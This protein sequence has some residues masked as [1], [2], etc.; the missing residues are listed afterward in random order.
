MSWNTDEVLDENLALDFDVDA[1]EAQ[2]P[3]SF[4]LL[5]KGEY[6][7]VITGM[8]P[9]ASKKVEG[10]RYVAMEVTIVAGKAKGRKV[11]GNFT[12]HNTPKDSTADAAERAAKAVSIGRGQIKAAFLAVGVTGS[13]VI[14]LLAAKQPIVV[15]IGVEKGN[16]AYP[17]DKNSIRG[18]KA[19]TDAQW[20]ALETGDEPAEPTAKTPAT[21]TKTTKT[22]TRPSF[23]QKK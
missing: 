21:S 18:F 2:E 23:L 4:D 19:M 5:A 3:M 20:V 8:S 12:T 17:E 11:W 13:S 6:P 15:V 14:D 16:A 10:S 1:A 9:K 7:A 22:T